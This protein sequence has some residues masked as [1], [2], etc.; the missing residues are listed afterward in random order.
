MLVMRDNDHLRV[1]ELLRVLWA[2]DLWDKLH[3][4]IKSSEMRSVLDKLI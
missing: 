3:D 1:M 4:N 2:I